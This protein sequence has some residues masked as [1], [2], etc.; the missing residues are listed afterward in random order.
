VI[1]GEVH[2]AVVEVWGADRCH[3]DRVCCNGTI[4][5]GPLQAKK[6]LACQKPD[7][8]KKYPSEIE[9]EAE[10]AQKSG[11]RLTRLKRGNA[12]GSA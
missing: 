2:E 7:K 11:L 3:L 8:C 12:L 1:V 5:S 4:L 10:K 6:Q 9:A